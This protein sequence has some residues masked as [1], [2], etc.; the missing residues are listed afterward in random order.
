MF[1]SL[2]LK[3]ISIFSRHEIDTNRL[4]INTLSQN[5]SFYHFYFTLFCLNNNYYF[6]QIKMPKMS[7]QSSNKCQAY[8]TIFDTSPLII[9]PFPPVISASDIVNKRKP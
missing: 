1:L 5:V 3:N 9:L 6:P 7:C 4:L 2:E 8:N